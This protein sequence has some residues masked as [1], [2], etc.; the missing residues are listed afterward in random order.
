MLGRTVRDPDGIEGS[1]T[2]VEGLGHLDI[3][4]VME[5]E[6]TV[7][8]VEAHSLQF[9]VPLKGYEIHLG[10]TTGPDCERPTSRINGI[11]DGAMSA[12]G[13][14]FGTYMH[15]LFGADAF[16]AALLRSMGIAA[17]A[18][19]YSAGVDAAL[20]SIAGQLSEVLDIDGIVDVQTAAMTRQVLLMSQFRLTFPG[21]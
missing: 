20:D 2:E 5:P 13:K 11:E 12:D 7:R 19:D 9:D 1:V 3:D 14:V 15:G 17:D 16:R 18:F 4:T 6:K 10:R 21:A 8:N